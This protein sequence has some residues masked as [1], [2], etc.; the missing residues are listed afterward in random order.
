MRFRRLR[1]FPYMLFCVTWLF[2]NASKRARLCVSPK[3]CFDAV[4]CDHEFVCQ[5]KSGQCV[6]SQHKSSLQLVFAYPSNCSDSDC[7]CATGLEIATPIHDCSLSNPL[8]LNNATNLAASPAA[9]A[10][11]RVDLFPRTAITNAIAQ[12][13]IDE[14]S[15]HIL[16]SFNNSAWAGLCR[17][18]F[19]YKLDS[20][21]TNEHDGRLLLWLHPLL[22]Q[23]P[24]AATSLDI[25]LR[26]FTKL[27]IMTK[28]GERI[29]A[30]YIHS[31]STTFPV[32]VLQPLALL[33]D[34]C[35]SL[36]YKALRANTSSRAAHPYNHAEQLSRTM[37]TS[38][39][40][41][42]YINVQGFVDVLLAR[43]KP[44]VHVFPR[45]V[46]AKCRRPWPHSNASIPDAAGLDAQQARHPTLTVVFPVYPGHRRWLQDA[47]YFQRRST[48][49]PDQVVV[50]MPETTVE[51]AVEMLQM[52]SITKELDNRVSIAAILGA[53][54]PG[55]SRNLAASQSHMTL[56]S[57]LDA[58]DIPHPQR[59]EIARFLW[60][61]TH[62]SMALMRFSTRYKPPDDYRCFQTK[63][64][65]DA[66]IVRFDKYRF[67]P[68][69][70]VHKGV[71]ILETRFWSLV[72]WDETLTRGEDIRFDKQL[73]AMVSQTGYS[74]GVFYN[75]TDMYFYLQGRSS[76]KDK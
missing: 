61:Q 14:P 11:A 53:A 39:L 6:Q 25:P 65:L 48:S 66:P 73:M 12:M 57:T 76:S 21:I 28:H 74:N 16:Y 47:I 20:N 32:L 8:W 1:S 31:L 68:G 9:R 45:D 56:L 35:N 17:S 52:L 40:H 23:H 49:Q 51:E 44:Q 5:S 72:Q 54:K 64:E 26:N 10:C 41:A 71:P 62:Y 3:K 34:A 38:F 27:R 18:D 58:D 19:G 46:L 37:S 70:Y 13:A 29:V 36:T 42:H 24:M 33:D 22:R 4:V 7:R 43:P 2:T 67:S 59:N 50:G 63:G 30:V 75:A 15:R 55:R 69:F 60:T